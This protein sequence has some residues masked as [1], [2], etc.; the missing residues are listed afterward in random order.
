MNILTKRGSN[1]QPPQPF[2]LV[3]DVHVAFPQNPCLAYPYGSVAALRVDSPKISFPEIS[4]VHPLVPRFYP[5][6]EWAAM[7]PVHLRSDFKP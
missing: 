1:S 5:H 7:G 3:S 6:S 4:G 2:L